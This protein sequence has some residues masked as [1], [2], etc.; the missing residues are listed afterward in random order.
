MNVSNRAYLDKQV[1]LLLQRSA[2][3]EIVPVLLFCLYPNVVLIFHL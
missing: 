1:F 2:C 3:L